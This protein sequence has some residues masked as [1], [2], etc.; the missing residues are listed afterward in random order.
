MTSSFIVVPIGIGRLLYG[1]DYAIKV[2][3]V[4]GWNGVL[5]VQE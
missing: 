5:K 1:R 4:Y 2:E 3:S